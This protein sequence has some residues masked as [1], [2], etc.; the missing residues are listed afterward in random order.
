MGRRTTRRDGIGGMT[1]RI[2]KLLGNE[3]Y[4]FTTLIAIMVSPVDTYDKMYQI[5]CFK[6]VQSMACQL[7]LNHTV[8][9]NVLSNVLKNNK[10]I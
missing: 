9:K 8:F 1:K 2:R 10:H 7:Y 6:Y 3:G 5:V 4:M